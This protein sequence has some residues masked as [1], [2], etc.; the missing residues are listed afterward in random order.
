MPHWGRGIKLAEAGT[1]QIARPDLIRVSRSE[2]LLPDPERSATMFSRFGYSISEA[3]ADLVDNSIDAQARHVL[4]R[5]VRTQEKIVRVLIADDGRGMDD[6]KL[7][8]AMRFGSRSDKS[9]DALGKYGFGLKT[10]SLSQARAVTV[11]SKH[12][13]KAAA[14]IAVVAAAATLPKL[15]EAIASISH[16]VPRL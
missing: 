13:G 6:R 15:V 8:E 4:V 7:S 3:I 10:A 12:E 1:L 9:T 14:P 2:Q 5:F 16:L 11:L